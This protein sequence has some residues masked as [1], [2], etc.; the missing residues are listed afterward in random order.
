MDLTSLI[1]TAA[2]KYSLDPALLQ[3]VIMQESAGN[4]SAVSSKGAQGLMQLMQ[5]TAAILGVTDALDPAQNVDAG[6][7]YL[8]G[9][10]NQFGGNTSLALAAYNAGPGA[11][12]Q[13]GG[14]PPFPETQNYVS[15]IL[16]RIGQAITA[17]PAGVDSSLLPVGS[18]SSSG[19]T[20]VAWLAIAAAAAVGLWAAS[21]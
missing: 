1:Q 12:A 4:P 19:L 8:A 11:V 18:A 20:G 3:A 14:V 17:A 7:R 5:A 10:L 2:A 16:S 6:A 15:T 21:R 13:Y 9:L